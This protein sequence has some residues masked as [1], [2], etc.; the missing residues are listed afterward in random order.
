MNGDKLRFRLI[1]PASSAKQNVECG[2]NKRSSL[3]TS[4]ELAL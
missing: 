2:V 1:N 3:F 4:S